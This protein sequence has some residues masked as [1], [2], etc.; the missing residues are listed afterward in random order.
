LE[1]E[2]A[3]SDRRARVANLDSGATTSDFTAADMPAQLRPSIL[4]AFL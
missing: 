1:V 2:V 4:P 3:G